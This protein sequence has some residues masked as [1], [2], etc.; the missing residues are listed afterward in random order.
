MKDVEIRFFAHATEDSNLVLNAVSN[1]LPPKILESVKLKKTDL[2]GHH[3]NP[4]SLYEIIFKKTEKLSA[5][6]SY[7]SEN[8]SEADKEALSDHARLYVSG[9]SLYLRLDKQ[10]ALAGE[11]FLCREDPIRI[12]I[13]FRRR[14]P[15]AIIEATKA[16]GLM[17]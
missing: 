3:G 13:R 10:R 1:V 8:L 7:L 6:L 16:L 15:E 9:G 11:F 12:R 14:K 4:I 2:K 5:V 17:L